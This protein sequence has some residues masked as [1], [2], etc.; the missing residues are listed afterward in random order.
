MCIL[1]GC[2]SLEIHSGIYFSKN[3]L[4]GAVVHYRVTIFVPIQLGWD[5][6]LLWNKQT[7]KCTVCVG[8]MEMYQDD[9]KSMSTVHAIYVCGSS[10]LSRSCFNED[11]LLFFHSWGYIFC[12]GA[13][14]DWHASVQRGHPCHA[15]GMLLKLN[16][17][18]AWD[19][20][21]NT[22]WPDLGPHKII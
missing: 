10:L 14:F 7:A 22:W 13:C 2:L 16:R 18:R 19:V 4:E 8:I 21:L 20:V 6:V 15:R 3:K 1:H 9:F 17:E 11:F 12:G 5:L